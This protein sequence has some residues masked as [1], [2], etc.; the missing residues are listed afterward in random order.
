MLVV[1]LAAALSVIGNIILSGLA[2][3]LHNI[4]VYA[5][6]TVGNKGATETIN[7]TVEAPLPI[8]WFIVAIVLSIAGGVLFAVYWFTKRR[9]IKGRSRQES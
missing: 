2:N 9:R 1:V 6:D 8:T 7:F 4:I 3:G 5:T